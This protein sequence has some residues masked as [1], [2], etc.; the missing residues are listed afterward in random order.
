ME[1]HNATTSSGTDP[2]TAPEPGE[3]AAVLLDWYGRHGRTLPWRARPGETPDAY[4]VW[5]SEI[6]LQQTTV[7]TV[8]PYFQAFLGRWPTVTDLAAADL[9]AVLHAWQ[10]LGY[11]SRARN[12][13]KCARTVTERFGGRFPE[14]ETD[15]LALPGI[16]PY[17]AAAIAAIAYGKRTIPI[18]GNVERVFSRL[19]TLDD[20]LPGLKKRIAGHA[21]AIMPDRPADFW[22]AVMDLGATVCR[23]RNPLCLTCPWAPACAANREGTAESY[24]R[25]VKAKAKPTRYGV[26]FLVR[27]GEGAIWLRRR[28]ESGLLGGMI[29]V[30]STEW[31][32]TPWKTAEAVEAAPFEA[33]WA[34]V[35]GTVRHTFTHF[36]LELTL[37]GAETAGPAADG[38]FWCP[39]QG[40]ADQALPTVMK[41]LLRLAGAKGAYSS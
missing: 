31:R 3:L 24:P 5:L 8:G 37:L 20:P 2:G 15:L 40:L 23:P 34:A 36:H 21:S 4:R 14:D 35:D 19:F 12:L 11:Y 38:G 26:A 29:E 9:D 28:P 39:P 22:Q 27:N 7:A 33:S 30:P 10:G 16:G 1:Q 25:K 13:H 17:T 32:E 18:D 6:M 41:K